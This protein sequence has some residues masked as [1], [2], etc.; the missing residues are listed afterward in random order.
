[1]K[2]LDVRLT[3][4]V[5]VYDSAD[6]KYANRA[7]FMIKAFG[8]KNVHVLDGGLSLWIS[9]GYQ[10]V[11]D[12][13]GIAEEDEFAYQ[14]N[15][16]MIATHQEV[17]NVVNQQQNLD[18]ESDQDSSCDVQFVDARGKTAFDKK[19]GIPNAINIPVK[20]LQDKEHKAL[21]NEELG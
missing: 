2:T 8:H 9:N 12:E 19:R 14:L 3:D 17:V 21:S 18:K 4:H 20:E 7:A 10:T 11:M 15:T 5:V 6:G 16:D 1:M 13:Q